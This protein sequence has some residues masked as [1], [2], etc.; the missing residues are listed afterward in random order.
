[1]NKGRYIGLSVSNCIKDI[2]EGKI[3][4]NQVIGIVGGTRFDEDSIDT[5]SAGY[6]KSYWRHNPIWADSLLTYFYMN[7]MIIQPRNTGQLP[8][9]PINGNWVKIAL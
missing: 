9:Q 1:M 5:V 4:L 3:E 7:D 6:S 2:I 8:I